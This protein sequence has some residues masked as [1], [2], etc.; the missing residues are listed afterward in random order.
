MPA[1]R[2]SW[3]DLR[4][5]DTNPC[6]PRGK[7][8]GKGTARATNSIIADYGSALVQLV[9]ASPVCPDAPGSRK[10]RLLRPNGPCN[11]NMDPAR[12]GRARSVSGVGNLPLQRWICQPGSLPRREAAWY[13]GGVRALPQA[14]MKFLGKTFGLR[15]SAGRSSGNQMLRPPA[16]RLMEV[17]ITGQSGRS[18][19]G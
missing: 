10:S 5:S 6:F 1:W 11:S 12:H 4:R 8:G 19:R 3:N 7:R 13:A 18:P 17:G 9:A 15:D 16:Q 14:N 2:P